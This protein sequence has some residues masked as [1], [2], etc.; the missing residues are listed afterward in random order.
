MRFEI[1]RSVSGEWF[2]H[3]KARNGRIIACG[4]GYRN[5]YGMFRVLRGMFGNQFSYALEKAIEAT[6]VQK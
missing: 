3:A 4:E 1:W 5:R 2:W 6:K